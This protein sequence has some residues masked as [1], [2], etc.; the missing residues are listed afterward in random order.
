MTRLLGLLLAVGIGLSVLV[1]THEA[2][3]QVYVGS[4]VVTSYYAPAPVYVRPRVAA[5]Y[6]PAPTET[7][8]APEA[9]PVVTSYYASAP[10]TTYYAP[11]T[12]YYAPAPVTSYYAP[13]PVTSYYAPT[14]A[15]YAPTTAYYAPTTAYYGSPYYVR[16]KVYVA[17]EPVRNFFR[18]IT[19]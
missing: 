12:T 13:A 10:V 17:G 19:P 14:T 18:A 5:Y 3:A 15:Y 16:P 4:P 1:T 7:Y 2:Q 6:A 9:G 8:Y 11:T